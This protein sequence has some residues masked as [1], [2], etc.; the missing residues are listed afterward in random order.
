MNTKKKA[1]SVAI[2]M[3]VVLA[4]SSTAMPVQA[5][6]PSYPASDYIQDIR[7]GSEDDPLDYNDGGVRIKLTSE[8]DSVGKYW[9]GAWAL[10]YWT[11]DSWES[12]TGESWPYYWRSRDTV[13]FEIQCH[14]LW[15]WVDTTQRYTTIS[16]HDGWRWD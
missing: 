6:T 15:P 8:G 14:C 16:F 4:I 2:A 12:Q 5:E 9:N 11:I 7:V 1:I 10:S 13:A 3:L